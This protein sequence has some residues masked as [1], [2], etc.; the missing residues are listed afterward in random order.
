[1]TERGLQIGIIMCGMCEEGYDK[2]LWQMPPLTPEEQEA[3]ELHIARLI[4]EQSTVELPDA[5]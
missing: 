2:I 3:I 1:M 5:N 4:K